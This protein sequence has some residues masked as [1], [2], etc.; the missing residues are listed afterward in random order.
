MCTHN[1]YKNL[2]GSWRDPHK[3]SVDSKKKSTHKQTHIYLIVSS[4]KVFGLWGGVFDDVI[5]F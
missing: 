2:C 1:E 3:G 5:I 4:E